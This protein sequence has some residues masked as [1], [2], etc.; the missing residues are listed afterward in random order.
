MHSSYNTHYVDKGKLTH[1]K[2]FILVKIDYFFT[3]F[4][5]KQTRQR[6]KEL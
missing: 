4:H 6:V 2:N 1:Q 5:V 3:V